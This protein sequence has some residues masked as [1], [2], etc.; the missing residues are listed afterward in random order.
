MSN[1]QQ[2]TKEARETKL[3]TWE[4][5]RRRGGVSTGKSDDS[6]GVGV[7]SSGEWVVMD[8]DG[9]RLGGNCNGTVKGGDRLLGLE[10]Q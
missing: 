10:L 9:M 6:K 7:N 8:G 2:K 5:A 4:R 3:Y 1:N